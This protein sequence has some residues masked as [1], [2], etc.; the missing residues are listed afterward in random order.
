MILIDV[1]CRDRKKITKYCLQSL[2][3]IK[4]YGS[5]LIARNDNSLEY[6]KNW[7]LDFVDEV[8][9][10]DLQVQVESW[11]RIH[12]IRYQSLVDFLQTDFEYLYL[13]DND[14]IHECY[15]PGGG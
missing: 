12:Y 14:V 7:L 4:P 2:Q 10:V 3:R 15:P 5:K 6:D 11:R 8:I 13:V 1:T 9:D